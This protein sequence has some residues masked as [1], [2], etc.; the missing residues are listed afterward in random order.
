[1]LSQSLPQ[2]LGSWP[3]D[4]SRLSVVA[5]YLELINTCQHLQVRLGSAPELSERKDFDL[6]SVSFLRFNSALADAPEGFCIDSLVTDPTNE[7]RICMISP[8]ELE[9]IHMVSAEL[10]HRL[11]MRALP[12]QSICSRKRFLRYG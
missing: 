7:H 5:N 1:M 11:C 12:R 10:Y 4:A 9:N 8:H 3:L 6:D 2:D